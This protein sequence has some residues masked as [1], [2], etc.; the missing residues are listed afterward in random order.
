MRKLSLPYP[1][2]TTGHTLPSPLKFGNVEKP[3]FHVISLVISLSQTTHIE[4]QGHP[5][6]ARLL[7]ALSK[8]AVTKGS[9]PAGSGPHASCPLPIPYGRKPCPASDKDDVSI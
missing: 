9:L 5:Q 6:S 7:A 4:I 1:A 8:K 3:H 2:F